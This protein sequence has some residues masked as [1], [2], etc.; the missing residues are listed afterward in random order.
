[1]IYGPRGLPNTVLRCNS[2][3]ESPY[4]PHSGPMLPNLAAEMSWKHGLY[5]CMYVRVSSD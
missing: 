2:L 4:G 3:C 1:M 5:V